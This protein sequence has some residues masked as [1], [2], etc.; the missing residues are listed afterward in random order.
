MLCEYKYYL[1][2]IPA[3]FLFVGL[4]LVLFRRFRR[5]RSLDTRLARAI[6]HNEI[7]PYYQPIVKSDGSLY[8]V[9]ILARWPST[10]QEPISPDLFI[11]VAEANGS[12]MQITHQLMSKASATLSAV[13]MFLPDEMHIGI[14]IAPAHCSDATF[15]EDCCHFIHNFPA[16]TIRLIAELT[17]RQPLHINDSVRNTL[18]DLH[19]A[20]IEIA[21]DDFGIGYS[22]LDY[23]RTLNVTMLKIDKSFTSAIDKDEGDTRLVESVLSIAHRFGLT[24]IAE[25][26]ET[27]YQARWLTSHGVTLHQG[28]LY[29]P[30]LSAKEFIKNWLPTTSCK[31]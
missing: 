30:P 3:I 22:G 18:R 6:D 12:L 28:F 20:G 8:G 17:E 25:G 15:V 13:A 9:E 31:I 14:N 11:P 19:D 27:E 16:N 26:V 2:L 1:L 10:K 7:E 21:L 24:V 23:L 5:E 4:A 29:S